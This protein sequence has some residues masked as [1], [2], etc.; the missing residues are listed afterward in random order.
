MAYSLLHQEAFQ[1]TL[2]RCMSAK[3]LAKE[4][5]KG[6]HIL[7]YSIVQLKRIVQRVFGKYT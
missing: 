3:H 2:K 6:S 1:R 4:E 5:N 7:F